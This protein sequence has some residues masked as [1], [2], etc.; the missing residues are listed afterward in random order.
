MDWEQ[1]VREPFHRLAAAELLESYGIATTLRGEDLLFEVARVF[2]HLPYE[3][4]TKLIR[5]HTFP[6]GRERFRLPGDVVKEHREK[7]AGGTCFSLSCLFGS[8]LDTFGISSYPVIARMRSQ[9]SMHCGLIVTCGKDKFLLDPGYLVHKPV[10]LKGDGVSR[11]EM[12][13]GQVELVGEKNK[14]CFDLFS[15]GKW[16]YSFSDEPMTVSAFM[17]LWLESFDWSMMNNIHLSKIIDGGYLYARGHHVRRNEHGM[18]SNENIRARQV[19]SLKGYFG[20]S[21]ELAEEALELVARSRA[22]CDISHFH[23]H[24]KQGSPSRF[25][26]KFGKDESPVKEP[27]EKR[28]PEEEPPDKIPPVREPPIEQPPAGEPPRKRPPVKEPPVKEPPVRA[29]TAKGSSAKRTSAKRTSA[30]RS[31]AEGSS[32]KGPSPEKERAKEPSGRKLRTNSL[33]SGGSC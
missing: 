7:G 20:I 23:S 32:V 21:G 13:T 29:L 12:E 27:P 9:R 24:L 19:E 3:N 22:N 18:K 2:C 15:G 16:R 30:K 26:K 28:P 31:S 10:R 33:F 4:L 5:K 25:L 6:H 14:Q 1:I 11:M 8:A 17:N